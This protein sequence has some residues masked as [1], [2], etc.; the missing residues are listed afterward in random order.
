MS[1]RKEK[2]SAESV[3]FLS[4][5]PREDL[6][7]SHRSRCINRIRDKS[8]NKPAPIP[9][10][11]QDIGHTSDTIPAAGKLHIQTAGTESRKRSHG[12]ESRYMSKFSAYF[13]FASINSRRGSTRSPMR[14]EKISSQTIASSISTFKSVRFSGSIVVSH[15]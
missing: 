8:R 6:K 1:E 15:S 13:A 3:S 14:T 9:V 4:D 11:K 2:G 7:L 10:H 5:R 12:T